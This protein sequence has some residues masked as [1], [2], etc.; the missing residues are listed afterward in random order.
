MLQ[1]YNLGILAVATLMLVIML[2]TMVMESAQHGRVGGERHSPVWAML[3][4]VLAIGLLTPIAN[5]YNGAQI[6][7]IQLAHAGS[8]LANTL[9][10]KFSPAD[11]D[12]DFHPATVTGEN[13]SRFL[14]EV[15]VDET[16]LAGV[17]LSRKLPGNQAYGSVTVQAIYHAAGT[18]SKE[19]QGDAV[20]LS[21]NGAQD[22]IEYLTIPQVILNEAGAKQLPI[23]RFR[24]HYNR[25]GSDDYC[26]AVE[27]P[28]PILSSPTASGDA[29]LYLQAFLKIRHNLAGY[30]ASIVAKVDAVASA[31][32]LTTPG[33]SAKPQSAVA[34]ANFEAMPLLPGMAAQAPATTQADELPP[35]L[36]ELPQIE[37][38]VGAWNTFSEQFA[39][40]LTQAAQKVAQDYISP[41]QQPVGNN[42]QGWGE[43]G[44]VFFRV[45]RLSHDNLKAQNYSFSA[46]LPNDVIL[47]DTMRAGG[48]PA[49]CTP[50]LKT[51]FRPDYHCLPEGQETTLAL[52]VADNLVNSIDAQNGD[53]LLVVNEGPNGQSRRQNQLS[54]ELTRR[55]HLDSFLDQIEGNHGGRRRIADHQRDQ[56]W[57]RVA[58]LGLGFPARFGG[59]Q[60]QWL[61]RSDPGD[62][63]RAFLWG[64]VF[65]RLLPAAVSADP[66]LLGHSQL[67]AQPVRGAG[68][69][70]AGGTGQ[71]A[72]RGRGAVCL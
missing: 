23:S 55:G 20:P 24:L 38:D 9:W 25:L 45:A 42:N 19:T 71:F 2:I 49:V 1:V 17:A 40:D 51:L 69:P 30:A 65:P 18:T 10:A 64:R 50:L 57:Q 62:F 34:G 72:W 44:F 63:C 66:F 35:T 21:L 11:L 12:G 36:P 58:A 29:I 3:R 61:L 8:G 48:M 6:A 7:A 22:G 28:A 15:L 46:V 14:E 32:K 27:I 41:E 43:A 54:A 68:S 37:I 56:W 16:C 59:R 60:Q 39:T 31:P 70:P 33:K 26:G 52:K 47:P 13:P 67:A 4:L 53:D 5:G